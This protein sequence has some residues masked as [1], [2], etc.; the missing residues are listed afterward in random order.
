M[1][2]KEEIL[3]IHLPKIGHSIMKKLDTERSDMVRT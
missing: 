3:F 1:N 2:L